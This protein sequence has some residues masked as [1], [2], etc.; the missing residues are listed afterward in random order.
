MPYA[1]NWIIIRR[2]TLVSHRRRLLRIRRPAPPTPATPLPRPLSRVPP[3][4]PLHSPTRDNLI[5]SLVSDRWIKHKQNLREVLTLRCLLLLQLATPS[6]RPNPRTTLPTLTRLSR[7]PRG[8][9]SPRPESLTCTL[10]QGGL[11]SR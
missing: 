1:S 11:F 2:R 10:G 7:R 8:A 5:C 9:T 3:P 6:S 4:S